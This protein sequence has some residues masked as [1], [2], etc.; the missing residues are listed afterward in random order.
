MVLRFMLGAV[1]VCLQSNSSKAA[2]FEL[3]RSGEMDE[4]G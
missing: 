1:L 3:C 2:S 4:V